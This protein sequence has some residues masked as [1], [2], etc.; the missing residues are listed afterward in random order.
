MI[1]LFILF[2]V[3]GV[4]AYVGY[5]LFIWSG[6]LADRGKKSIEKSNLSFTQEGGLKVNVKHMSSESFADK[7]QK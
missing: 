6:E 2:A 4:F 3:L 5:Q 7:T 1:P